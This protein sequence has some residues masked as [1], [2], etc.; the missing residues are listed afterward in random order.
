[1]KGREKNIQSENVQGEKTMDATKDTVGIS[2]IRLNTQYG[3][4][5]HQVYMVQ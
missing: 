4:T 5:S 1:M 3:S 2:L